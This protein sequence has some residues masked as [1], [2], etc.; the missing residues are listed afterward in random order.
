M[1]AKADFV[2]NSSSA[3]FIYYGW[4]LKLEDVIPEKYMEAEDGVWGA[5]EE[6]LEAEKLD[7][8]FRISE[9]DED[10]GIIGDY[11]CSVDNGE[12]RK[13]DV[14]DFPTEPTEGMKKF[15]ELLKITNEPKIFVIGDIMC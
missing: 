8:E 10:H 12:I 11:I 5:L 2:T 13:L 1:K 7:V 6:F 9:Y 4:D 15:A 14:S 3:A